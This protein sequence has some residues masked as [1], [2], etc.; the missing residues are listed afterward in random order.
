MDLEDRQVGRSNGFD[1]LIGLRVVEPLPVDKSGHK[2]FI[3][4]LIGSDNG[5]NTVSSP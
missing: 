3:P 2:A 1:W 5:E 4:R